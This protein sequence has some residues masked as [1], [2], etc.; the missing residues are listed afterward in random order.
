MSKWYCDECD[1]VELE[2]VGQKATSDGPLG[3]KAV[4][5]AYGCPRCNHIYAG[6]FILPPQG[7]D[8]KKEISQ[9]SKLEV[10]TGLTTTERAT[11]MESPEAAQVI[12][13]AFL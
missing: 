13:N 9:P 8:S 10:L 1:E 3:E 5:Y 11:V 7:R 4:K 6:L 12:L 2:F